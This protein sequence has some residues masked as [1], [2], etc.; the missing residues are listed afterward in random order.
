MKPL[1][2]LQAWATGTGLLSPL[3]RVLKGGLGWGALAGGAE[4]GVGDPL[5][6]T[7][8]GLPQAHSAPTPSLPQPGRPGSGQASSDAWWHYWKSQPRNHREMQGVGG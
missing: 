1:R 2:V 5:A 7:P 3:R 4:L 6:H 8:P